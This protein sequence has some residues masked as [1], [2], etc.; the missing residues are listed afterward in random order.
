MDARRA[1]RVVEEYRMLAGANERTTQAITSKWRLNRDG[2]YFRE[3]C[4]L[5]GVTPDDLDDETAEEIYG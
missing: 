3:L 5:A 1:A 4:D 2:A